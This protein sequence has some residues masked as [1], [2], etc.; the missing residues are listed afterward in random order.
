M[1]TQNEGNAAKPK[2]V[3]TDGYTTNPGDLSWDD[4]AA[5]GELT[6]YER[7][8]SQEAV[9]RCADADIVLSNKIVWTA[10][11][12][13]QLK[14]CKL[15]QLLSTGYNVVDYA[16]SNKQNII[17]CNV[18][19]YSTPD[20][21]Q[22]TLAL[23]LET[24][25][26]V[27]EYS[28]SV[29]LGNWI[30]SR[31]FTYYLDPIIELVGKTLGVIGMGS[32]GQ[33]VARL[34]EAFG[35]EIVF[36]NPHEKPELESEHCKQ[37]SLD[38]VLAHA[39]IVTL[40]CPLTP[41]NKGMVNSE[42]LGKM[43]RGATLINT[44]RGGLINSSDIAEALNSGQLGYYAADVSEEEPMAKDDPLRLAP[45]S[46]ITPHIAWAATAARARLIDQAVKN[47]AAFLEGAPINVVPPVV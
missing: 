1:T 44:A 29:R 24:T 3:I 38:D 28:E 5:L 13:S 20:V 16:Q 36:Y 23:I 6:V 41:S 30:E 9:K 34:A 15:L 43:K 4:L 8:S 18:P 42:F 33:H 12:I 26:H 10:E 31:D 40:H 11:M 45:H 25:N 7:S 17:V 2:I 21:A 22:H 39:D 27:A 14:N 46:T 32:I 19:A 37:M 47:V 35:M